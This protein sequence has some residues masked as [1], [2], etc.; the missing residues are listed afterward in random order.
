M[1]KADEKARAKI[2]KKEKKKAKKKK[3]LKW[4]LVVF[5]ASIFLFLGFWFWMGSL[6]YSATVDEVTWGVTFSHK[7][8]WQDL[9]VD[10]TDAYWQMITDLKVKDVRLVAHWDMIEER[11]EEYNF[12]DLEWMMDV[13][14][15]NDVNVLFTLGRRTPRWPECHDPAWIKNLSKVEQD[16]KLLEMMEK[17]VKHFRRYDNIIAW[18]VE[19]EPFL[20]V[21][22]ECP[23]PDE[24][25]LKREIELVRGLDDRPIVITD[26]G[27]LSNWKKAAARADIFGATMYR[28]VWNKFLGVWRYP[29]PAAYYYYKARKVQ[30]EF[31]LQGVIIVELQA[32]PW[33][34]GRDI[35]QVDLETQDELF[36]RDDFERNL[37][38]VR[39]AGFNKAYLWG[40][41]WWYWLK[42][43]KD[44][45]EFWDRAR[46]L[47]IQPKN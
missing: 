7:Y 31:D 30:D 21:F 14:E 26:T 6:D 43:V 4:I 29:W 25:L 18:Q 27:E 5:L 24:E 13:A 19:N 42:E 20:K 38:F 34:A 41:E 15:E 44:K 3:V 46:E 35:V 16:E 11:D 39:Q 36:S 8:A 28:T 17:T 47:W 10:W 1:E 45:P 22:G 9:G 12:A 33:G 23:P 32:E 2:V 37:T 40:V